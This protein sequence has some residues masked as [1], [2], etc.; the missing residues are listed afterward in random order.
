MKPTKMSTGSL[1]YSFQTKQPMVADRIF[2]LERADLR[3]VYGKEG[4]GAWRR[5]LGCATLKLSNSPKQGALA[6]A[7]AMV[8]GNVTVKAL[9]PTRWR[10]WPTVT[11]K[12]WILTGDHRGN[13]L[14]M[15]LRGP[16]S[17]T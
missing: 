17:N 15:I 9:I 2:S 7:F 16:S 8:G 12:F 5:G 14:C 1:T 4:K 3:G 13:I 6:S 10:A 11:L